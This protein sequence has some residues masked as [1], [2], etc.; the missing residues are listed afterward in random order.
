[1]IIGALE[2]GGSHIAAGRVDIEAGT[3]AARRVALPKDAARN[4]LLDRIRE[5]ADVVSGAQRLGVATPGPFDYTNGVSRLRHK[6]APLYGV[7]LRSEIASALGLATDAIRFLNDADAFLLGEWLTGAAR[8]VDR[9]LAVTL[10][11]G[12]GS[13]FLADGVLTPEVELYRLTFRGRPVEETLSARGIGGGAS[14][15][16]LATRAREGDDVARA[17]F[18]RAGADLGEFLLPHV[19][20]LCAK[21][22][23]VGGSIARAWDLFEHAVHTRVPDAVRAV[24]LDDA[25]L[26]GA[27]YHAA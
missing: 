20:R 21:R 1:V 23:V 4:E 15:A 5:A 16:T 24:N 10:G 12:L 3:V 9:V 8:G 17:A 27:A 25:A 7:D 26:V 11:T 2:L 22:V 18:E 6:L 19:H 14:V 13:A